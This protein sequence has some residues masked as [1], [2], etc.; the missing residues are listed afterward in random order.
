LDEIKGSLLKEQ[1][2]LIGTLERLADAA[3][4]QSEEDRDFEQ[5]AYKVG[6]A[7][8]LSMA[9]D[10]FRTI[11]RSEHVDMGLVHESG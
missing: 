6:K 11:G 1:W 9:T 5:K 10:L 7:D 4:K 8:G 2:M 3:R